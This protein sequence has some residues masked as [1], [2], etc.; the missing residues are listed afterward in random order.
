[1]ADLSPAEPTKPTA[2]DLQPMVKLA[3]VFSMAS[4]V[5]PFIGSIIAFVL[6][7]IGKSRAA[8]L[9][10]GDPRE[11]RLNRGMATIAQGVAT[12]TIVLYG[13]YAW[14]IQP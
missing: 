2:N 5:L 7:S 4:F 3:A 12:F 10:N 6:A 8:A 14:W 9:A 11:I 13:A 1:M